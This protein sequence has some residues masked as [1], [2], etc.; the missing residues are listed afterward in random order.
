MVILIPFYFNL[1]VYLFLGISITLSI[2]GFIL[3][4]LFIDFNLKIKKK[5]VKIKSKKYY[6]IDNQLGI[7]YEEDENGKITKFQNGQIY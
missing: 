4:R 3:N 1:G 2:I 5:P 6:S 7:V